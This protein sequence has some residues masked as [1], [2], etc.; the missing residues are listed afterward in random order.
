MS[1]SVVAARKEGRGKGARAARRAGDG[2][3][4]LARAVDRATI[5]ACAVLAL[6]LAVVAASWGRPPH[7][8]GEIVRIVQLESGGRLVYG[9]VSGTFGPMRRGFGQWIGPGGFDLL[10]EEGRALTL[11]GGIEEVRW[12]ALL[13]PPSW[14]RQEVWFVEALP[15]LTGFERLRVRLSDRLGNP[16]VGASVQLSGAH[17]PAGEVPADVRLWGRLSGVG[18]SLAK[19]I[20]AAEV[21]LQTIRR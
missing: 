19:P 6:G 9:R 14:W 20:D 8:G 3:S 18:A 7:L 12:H 15:P 4:R 2:K 17:V 11:E 5:A 10:T 1:N 13:W 16:V 21:E